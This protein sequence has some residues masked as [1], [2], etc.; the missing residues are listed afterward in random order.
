[1]IA[2]EK[3]RRAKG[4]FSSWAENTDEQ[5]ETLEPVVCEQIGLEKDPCPV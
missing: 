1:L 3:K 5:K 4:A 2:L